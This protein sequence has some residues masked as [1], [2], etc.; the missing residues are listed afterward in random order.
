MESDNK[1]HNFM[2][3]FSAAAEL[4]ARAAKQGCFIESVVLTAAIIDG[5]LR[6][7]LILKHQ[8]DHDTSELLP[9]LLYQGDSDA[10][11]IERKVY[12]RAL[13]E[14]VIGQGLFDE[15]NRLYDDRNRVIHRYVISSITTAEVLSI[16][17][18]YD[19]AKRNASDAVA[20][21]EEEQIR[22]GV[23][24][25]ARGPLPDEA[26]VIAFATGKHGDSGLAEALREGL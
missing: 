7:G 6:M 23:G 19:T 26:E 17:M 1:F 20:F 5:V 12:R 24:M 9:E 25:T 16:A 11:I 10:A 8:L 15:L 2:Q 14:A 22:L 3:S 21:L 13:D 18:R 4:D